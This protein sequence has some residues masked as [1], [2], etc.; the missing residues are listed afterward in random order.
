MDLD[1]TTTITGV[2]VYPDR[3]QIT[4]AGATGLDA[5]G[6]HTL[7]IGGLPLALLP[8]S[9]RA[10]GKGPAGTRILA[11]EQSHEANPS[12]PE[13]AIKALQGEIERLER[14][15]ALLDERL[16]SVQERQGWLS[17][18]GEQAVRSLAWGI[19]R[20]S[21]KPEDASGLFAYADEQAQYLAS[22]R[23]E[24]RTKVLK[25]GPKDRSRITP[26]LVVV[27]SSFFFATGALPETAGPVCTLTLVEGTGALAGPPPAGTTAYHYG[28][29]VLYESPA[30]PKGL[31][32]WS[33]RGAE[34]MAPHG[35]YRT[36][37]DDPEAWPPTGTVPGGPWVSHW[38]P[39]GSLWAD[40]R[41]QVHRRH[42]GCRS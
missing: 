25:G 42:R 6:E 5:P 13:E 27:W 14:E 37:F 1:L 12:A 29:L 30:G 32:A 40:G 22:S 7:R 20:G 35:P 16:R 2:T 24:I 21:T 19:A 34:G 11:V 31:E 28:D 17:T 26:A 39:L 36:I 15:I 23:Q 8:D 10:S 9:V 33:R 41:R 18:L 38:R 4:R 3:A